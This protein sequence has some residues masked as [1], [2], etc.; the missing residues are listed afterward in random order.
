M[1]ERGRSAEARTNLGML[2]KEQ[3]AFSQKNGRYAELSNMRDE[4]GS[5]LPRVYGVPGD[6]N[7]FDNRYFQYGC[8]SS[9]GTCTAYRCQMGGKGG[10]THSW[11]FCIK[12]DV[13]GNLRE[14]PGCR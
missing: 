8:D 13:N 4:L 3:I 7:D 1:I 12:L 10:G 11:P 2:R 6:C 14:M 9:S 5:G